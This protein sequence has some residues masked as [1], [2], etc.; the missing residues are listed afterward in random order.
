M[1]PITLGY[2]AIICGGLSLASPWLGSVLVRLAI[3]VG[4]GLGAAALLPTVHAA[5]TYS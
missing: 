3:G 4:V 1:D 5:L 2:Y